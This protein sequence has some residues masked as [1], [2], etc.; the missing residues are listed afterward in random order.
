M[1]YLYI[2]ST[3]FSAVKVDTSVTILALLLHIL[4]FY[5]HMS[6]INFIYGSLSVFL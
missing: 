1:E 3:K 4:L 6:K 5:V 2:I